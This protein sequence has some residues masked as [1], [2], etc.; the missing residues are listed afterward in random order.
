M[1]KLL[2]Q[3][4][5]KLNNSYCRGCSASIGEVS[6]L[7]K[8]MAED[9]RELKKEYGE[10]AKIPKGCQKVWERELYKKWGTIVENSDTYS[11]VCDRK[12]ETGG[13]KGFEVKRVKKMPFLYCFLQLALEIYSDRLAFAREQEERNLLGNEE[14]EKQRRERLKKMRENLKHLWTPTLNKPT[15]LIKEERLI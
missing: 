3:L 1:D 10:E 4:T 14:Y 5:D 11:I 8:Q 13:A 12:V 9:I 2:I 7:Y 6:E 15:K